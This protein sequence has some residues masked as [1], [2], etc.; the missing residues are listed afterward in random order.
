MTD[1]V[2]LL[3]ECFKAATGQG[4]ISDEDPGD[5][6]VR[7]NSVTDKELTCIVTDLFLDLNLQN[8]DLL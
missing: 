5:E 1:F 7:D 2:L 4:D 6:H 8:I 3:G